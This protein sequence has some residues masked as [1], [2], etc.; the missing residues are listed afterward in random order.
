MTQGTETG[1]KNWGKPQIMMPPHQKESNRPHIA[2][3]VAV[4]LNMKEV[5]YL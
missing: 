1:V 2:Y 4:Q 5:Y 3:R